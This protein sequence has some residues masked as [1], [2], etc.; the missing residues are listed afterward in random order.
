M[1]TKFQ[2]LVTLLFL[3]V[4]CLARPTLVSDKELGQTNELIIY[5]K[6]YMHI[7]EIKQCVTPL[8][9][10]FEIKPSV[11]LNKT[12]DFV[13]ATVHGSKNFIPE[14]N[15]LQLKLRKLP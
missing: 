9:Q 2:F 8:Q 5:L 10:H 12:H 6:D 7:E 15:E 13:V 11:A 4:N 3:W 1:G 14:L